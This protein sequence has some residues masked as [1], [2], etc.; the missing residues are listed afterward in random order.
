MS[1]NNQENKESQGLDSKGNKQVQQPSPSSFNKVVLNS[2]MVRT[3]NQK[4]V[5]CISVDV[6]HISALSDVFI[7]SMLARVKRDAEPDPHPLF[8]SGEGGVTPK[9]SRPIDP[10]V[11]RRLIPVMNPNNKPLQE[12]KER[13]NV[14][15]T[16]CISCKVSVATCCAHPCRCYLYCPKCAN[17]EQ[18]EECPECGTDIRMYIFCK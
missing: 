18:P 15:E 17:L 14:E 12:R 10:T 7:P 13:L 2:G 3:A 6:N 5:P 1:D 8:S 11:P 4:L 9:K 16:G